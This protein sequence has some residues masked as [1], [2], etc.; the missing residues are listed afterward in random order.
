[1]NNG[2]VAAGQI[3]ISRW[4]TARRP[5][6]RFLAD[7]IRA[8]SACPSASYALLPYRPKTAGPA[9]M[10][11][12]DGTPWEDA[13]H[14]PHADE[15]KPIGNWATGCRWHWKPS[16][17]CSSRADGLHAADHDGMFTVAGLDRH[18]DLW[19]KSA[20][21]PCSPTWV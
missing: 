3:W 7:R 4:R 8:T 5:A 14:L 12:E 20:S 17:P 21:S 15:C 9:F 2:V 19:G 18:Y 16:S 13:P 1:M 10:R 6:R 11:Q